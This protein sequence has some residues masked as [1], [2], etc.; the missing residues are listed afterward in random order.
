MKISVF[1]LEISAFLIKILLQLSILNKN[2]MSL[3]HLRYLYFKEVSTLKGMHTYLDENIYV[4][5][6][7]ER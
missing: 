5:Y 3:K 7:I 1:S 4:L 6:D 2:I